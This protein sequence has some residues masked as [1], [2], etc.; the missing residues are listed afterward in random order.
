[1]SK[2][3]LTRRQFVIGAAALP[4]V[5][6]SQT[7]SDSLDRFVPKPLSLW[8]RAPAEEWVQ[9]L[10]IGNGRIGAM[11]FGG[12]AIERLSLN[13]DTFFAGGPYNP[14]N[15]EAKAALPEVRKLIL[16]GEYAQ[17]Q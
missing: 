3:D 10:P 12:L 6:Q 2:F 4:V 1:M 17:A 15:P 13:E 8:Y 11:I 16:E 14:V 7:A 5:A 9:A